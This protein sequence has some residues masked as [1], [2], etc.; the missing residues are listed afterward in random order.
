MSC[1]GS[2]SMAIGA[3]TSSRTSVPEATIVLALSGTPAAVRRPSEMSFWT[4][5]RDR[6]VA[7]A[8]NRSIR[9]AGPSGTRS[10]R[11][12]AAT[13][14]SGIHGL[15]RLGG[16]RGRDRP[17]GRLALTRQER[18]DDQEQDRAADGHV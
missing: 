9:L 15:R 18:A 17:T 12:P 16:L 11:T 1:D 10:V 7:S 2:R 3:G 13:G 6:P 14:A 8:T 5:L 4:W